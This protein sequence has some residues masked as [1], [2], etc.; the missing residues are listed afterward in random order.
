MLLS[1]QANSAERIVSINLCTD[2]LL[3]L[4]ADR[5]QILSVSYLSA[6]RNYSYLADE[7]KTFPLNH[8]DV[9]E[10]IPLKPDLVLAGT[11][12]NTHTVH[13]LRSLG[14]RVE[15]VAIPWDM[16]H[17]EEGIQ[18]VGELLN[19][20]ERAQ[21]II[22]NMRQ[23][24]KMAEARVAGK[25]RPLAVILAP[26]GF[27]HG[28]GSMKGE[29]LGMAG[30]RNLAAEAGIVRNGNISLETLVQAQPDYLIIEDAA[31]NQNSLAQRL[32]QHPALK[33][34]LPNARRIAVHP[35]LWTC[36][37]PSMIDA[38]EILVDAHP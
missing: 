17:I 3:Y 12:T 10:I 23:R 29:L 32:L 14:F 6:D 19:R 11:Y 37:G 15:Q 27:T 1:L 5:E 31:N 16:A 4:L 8:A 38:L 25:N 34:G 33:E 35:N 20:Q 18:A 36:G 24:R 26:N 7:M 30:Y 2:Q 22:N 21:A 13:F 28:K 9:E